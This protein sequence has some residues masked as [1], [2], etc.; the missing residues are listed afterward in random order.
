MKRFP[1]QIRRQLAV[2]DGDIEAGQ[3]FE[4]TDAVDGVYC[5]VGG[6][7]VVVAECQAFQLESNN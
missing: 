5:G 3:R 4:G 6:L 2:V 1:E 7:F